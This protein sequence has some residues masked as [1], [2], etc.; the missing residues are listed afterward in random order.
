MN[1]IRGILAE[2]ELFLE[3]ST[4]ILEKNKKQITKHWLMESLDL[5][6]LFHSSKHATKKLAVMN[7]CLVFWF[8]ATA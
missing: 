4:N 3:L 2:Q 1:G 6:G 8:M 5:L 7:D